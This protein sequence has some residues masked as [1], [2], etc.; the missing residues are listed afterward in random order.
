MRLFANQVDFP[1]R[2]AYV[3]A[4]PTICPG[5]RDID[6][7]ASYATASTSPFIRTKKLDDGTTVDVPDAHHVRSLSHANAT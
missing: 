3:V 5:K 7:A 2:M 6:S 4:Y 1:C